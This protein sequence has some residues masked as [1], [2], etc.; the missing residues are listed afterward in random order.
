MSLKNPIMNLCFM[1]GRTTRKIWSFSKA[2]R[3]K[4]DNFSQL[5]SCIGKVTHEKGCDKIEHV[6]QKILHGLI[7]PDLSHASL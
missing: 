1:M 5:L 3:L 7:S 2:L 4:T 6:L